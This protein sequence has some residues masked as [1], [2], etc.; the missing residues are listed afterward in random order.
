[1]EAFTIHPKN[2]GRSVAVKVILKTLEVPFKKLGSPY[3]EKFVA[4][5]K[6]ADRDFKKGKGKIISP[7]EV[8]K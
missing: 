3:N 5:V 7:D 1:M 2:E 8:C 4:M 6:K